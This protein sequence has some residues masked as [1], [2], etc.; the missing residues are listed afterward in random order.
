MVSDKIVKPLAVGLGS[1]AVAGAIQY[2]SMGTAKTKWNATI[3][4]AAVAGVGGGLVWSAFQ[5]AQKLADD[6]GQANSV[7]LGAVAGAGLGLVGGFY[8]YGAYNIGSIMKSTVISTSIGACAGWLHNWYS[9]Q[10]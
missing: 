1:G 3:K 5:S 4:A 10:Q 9:S 2:S 6:A 7:K 8:A